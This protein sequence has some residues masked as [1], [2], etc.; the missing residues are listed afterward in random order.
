MT[1]EDRALIEAFRLDPLGPR[2]PALRRFLTRF[3]AQPVAGKYVLV[4]TRPHREWA[5]ARLG[6]AR[7]EPVT[8]T[9]DVFTDPAEAEWEIFRRRWREA[10]GD[11]LGP[12]EPC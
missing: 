9:G 6:G 3:R 11:D 12:R 2:P 1:D 4:A 7:G 10:G 5:L 8:L